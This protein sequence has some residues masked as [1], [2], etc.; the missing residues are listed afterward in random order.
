MIKV[1]AS[2]VQHKKYLLSWP[3]VLVYTKEKSFLFDVVCQKK[4]W[5]QQWLTDHCHHWLSVMLYNYCIYPNKMCS[6]A[7]YTDPDLLPHHTL[8]DLGQCGLSGVISTTNNTDPALQVHGDTANQDPC[9]LQLDSTYNR[10]DTVHQ[11]E[12]L[13]GLIRPS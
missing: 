9:C 4:D 6:T 13:L 11:D 5:H 12:S 8:A 1:Q 3:P 10:V 2:T 7:N